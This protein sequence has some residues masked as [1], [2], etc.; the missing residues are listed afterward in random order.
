MALTR[1]T[2][3]N[4]EIYFVDSK[5][6]ERVVTELDTLHPGKSPENNDQTNDDANDFSCSEC[7]ADVQKDD[8][9]CPKCGA[10]LTITE[11]EISENS[12]L[13]NDQEEYYRN[14]FLQFYESKEEYQGKWNWAAF[15]FTWIWA[16]MKGAWGIGLLILIFAYPLS[17]FTFGLAGLIV[18][19]VMGFKGN[20]I[21]YN[22][23]K[24]AH[25][26]IFTK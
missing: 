16:F 17:V 19:I 24:R 5:T 22:V 14:E 11:T 20:K 25:P 9:K 21:Y 1:M 13:F 23:Y 12:D 15:F 3:E 10:D 8:I 18:A 26:E 2:T 6:R 4:G 7:G